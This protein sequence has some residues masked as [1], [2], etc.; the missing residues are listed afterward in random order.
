MKP[1]PID[2]K[3]LAATRPMGFGKYGLVS[4]EYVVPLYIHTEILTHRRFSR[5]A[6]SA[7]A[8]STTR[9]AGLG[10]YMPPQFYQSQKGMEASAQP[11]KHQWLARMVWSAAIQGTELAARVLERLK[12]AK[13]QRNRLIAPAKM[14][15]GIITGTESAW[16]SFFHLRNNKNADTAMQVF[17]REAY[18]AI[19]NTRWS[20]DTIHAP[21]DIDPLV[22][23]ARAALVSYAKIES[24]DD[25]KLANRL[26]KDGHMSPFEHYAVWRLQPT[27]SNLTC[28]SNDVHF[29]YVTHGWEHHRATLE[30][31]NLTQV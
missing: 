10:Y 14:V 9:Y 3:I 23:A 31:N 7:R 25:Y 13:E 2:V 27:L 29:D 8:M 30:K 6:S 11:I 21:Y 4:I 12:V 1:T 15:K 17:A 22:N 18:H 20:Y 26:L 5:N 24:I 28:S 16:Q 19:I